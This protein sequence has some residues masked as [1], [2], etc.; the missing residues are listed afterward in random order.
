[1]N[2]L[3]RYSICTVL[4][5]LCYNISI[6][7]A[8]NY[9][10]IKTDASYYF[11]DSTSQAILAARI[12]SVAVAGNETR[13]FGM[14]QIRQTDYGCFIPNGESWMGE[15][16]SE[17]SNG[18]FQFVVYPFSPPDSANVFT[19]KSKGSLG[20]T[21]HFYNYHTI[22]HYVEAKVTQISL[23]NFWG[24][25]D[26]VKT[27]SLQR[28][29]ALGQNV[30][31]PIN[32]QRILLSKNYGLIRLPKFDDFNYNLAF[33]DLCGKTNPV[34]GLT[35]QTFEE[36]FDFQ[37]GDEFH[38]SYDNS[39][40]N[41]LY[42]V[43]TGSIIHRILE[44][45]SGYNGD[46]LSYKI[47]QCKT[48]AL[49]INVGQVTITNS[50]D[51]ILVN[52]V[53]SYYP[54]FVLEPKEPHITRLWDGPFELN[55]NEMGLSTTNVLDIAGIPWKLTD[56]IWPLWSNDPQQCFSYTMMDD[57]DNS[58]YFY[59]GLGGPYHYHLGINTSSYRKLVYFKKGSVSWGTPLD[60]QTILHTSIP[61]DKK[62]FKILISPNPVVNSA[63]IT[64]PETM[65]LPVNVEFTSISGSAVL[66][67]EIRNYNQVVDLSNL[68]A[69]IYLARFLYE[70]GSVSFEKF[71][72][73]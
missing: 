30:S 28:K 72:R 37:P 39:Y 13:Y 38:I 62:L 7:S 67:I 50:S 27:I 70:D 18:I 54:S 60:C 4:F 2:S 46:T 61:E 5:L 45:I 20:E 14:K 35:N 68:P 8:Q 31:D 11:Y 21:W 9:S 23:A 12:D 42:W 1:M 43:E 32:G 73:Q 69:G 56:A 52:Y 63:N 53:K 22:N 34:T 10:C 24:I 17:S 26:S 40:Y 44:R 55:N 49:S 6:V 57:Y 47:A 71:I 58:A 41:I 48:T 33:Y 66:S 51:T 15:Y 64:I 36:I 16:V 25:S 29:N 3:F 59:T 19:I 65:Q